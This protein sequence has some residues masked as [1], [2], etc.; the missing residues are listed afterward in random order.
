MMVEEKL[1]MV[2]ES[3]KRLDGAGIIIGRI[4]AVLLLPFVALL[5]L[6]YLPFILLSSN[7]S[8]IW[9]QKRPGYRGGDLRIP[10]FSTMNADASGKLRETWFGKIVRPLGLDEILQIYLIAKGDMQWFGPR[11]IERHL[12]TGDYIESVLS[13]TK[14]GFFN[15]RSLLTG[16][17]NRAVFA[18]QVSVAQMGEYDLYDLRQWSSWHAAKLVFRTALVVLRLRRYSTIPGL[19]V[20]SAQTLELE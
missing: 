7:E 2:S 20:V 13:L 1:R 11:P 18:G 4:V 12:L 15:S 6:L 14:P 17:G 9:W 16:I 10:K 3:R 19:N 8:P 5:T